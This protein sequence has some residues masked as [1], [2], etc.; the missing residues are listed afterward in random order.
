MPIIIPK[1]LPARKILE[2]EGVTVIEKQRA[3]SQDIRPLEIGLVNLMPQKIETETQIARLIGS[4]PLQ[5]NLSFILPEMYTPKK[6]S[7]VHLKAFYKPWDAI[8]NQHFDGLIITGAPV[9]HLN[10]E[11]VPYWQKIEHIFQW[12]HTNVY[13]TMCICWAAQA[14]L[15]SRFGINKYNL[16][17]KRFGIFPH[18]TIKAHPLLSG[19]NDL[20]D[21][22]VSRHTSIHREDIETHAKEINLLSV[23]ADDMQDP[24]IAADANSRLVLNFNHL[25]YDTN[26]LEDEYLRDRKD[27]PCHYFPENDATKPPLNTWRSHSQLFFANWINQI[28]QHTPYDLEHFDG[29]LK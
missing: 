22:P 28:Y 9:E 27:A 24:F 4:T 25:E 8:R 14:A 5:V 7:P 6:T 3:I 16:P 18:T 19:L 2:H 10:F 17:E 11:D 26:T 20:Y 21:V 29:N 12:S 15:Y 23:S 13:S 1:N